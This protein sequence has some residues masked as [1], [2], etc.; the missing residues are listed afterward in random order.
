MHDLSLAGGASL[1]AILPLVCAC[2]CEALPAP[3]ALFSAHTGFGKPCRLDSADFLKKSIEH[4]KTIGISPDTIYSGYVMNTQGAD[5]VDAARAAFPLALRVHDPAFADGGRIYSGLGNDVIERHRSLAANSN[6]IL[7]NISEALA[8]CGYEPETRMSFGKLAEL[9]SHLLGE[10]APA[11]ITGLELG[12]EWFNIVASPGEILR[13]PFKQL[14]GS[15]PGTGDAFGALVT[16][17]ITRGVAVTQAV[18]RAAKIIESTVEYTNSLKRDSLYG[19][20][21]AFA[22]RKVV[23]QE[24]ERA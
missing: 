2:G 9:C 24:N 5:T 18:E 13:I 23:N 20:S 17:Y 21:L 22:V 16:A 4:F 3:G 11:V 14:P 8:L 12:G 19:I 7:P 10:F 1:S 6:L 15:Y